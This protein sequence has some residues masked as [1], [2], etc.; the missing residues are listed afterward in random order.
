M[1]HSGEITNIQAM[2]VLMFGCIFRLPYLHFEASFQEK[3]AIFGTQLGLQVV[4]YSTSISM[5]VRLAILLVL[6]SI[7]S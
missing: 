3:I 1:I 6:L 2:I 4:A 7:A 5:F